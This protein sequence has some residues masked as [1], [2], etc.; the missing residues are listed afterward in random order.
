MAKTDKV[1]ITLQRA[2]KHQEDNL[3]VGINGKNYIIPRGVKVTV[4]K[5]V[6]DEIARSEGAENVFFAR[7]AAKAAEAIESAK[8]AGLLNN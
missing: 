8:A 6:A 2:A 3:F 4:P 1:E 7:T 5:A